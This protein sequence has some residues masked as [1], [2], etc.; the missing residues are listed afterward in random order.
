MVR[1]LAIFF[2]RTTAA[3]AAVVVWLV[4]PQFLRANEQTRADQDIVFGTK[5]FVGTKAWVAAKG[6]LTADWMAYKNNSFSI[7]CDPEACT[8]ASV[9]QIGPKQVGS[10]DGPTAYPVK[11]WAE[12]DE[13]VAEDDTLCSRITITLDR[14]TESV[15]WVET[16]RP[17]LTH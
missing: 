6:T 2:A 10:I 17:V 12:D 8:V 5:L 16:P 13:V 14:K 7:L 11:Q 9:N 4:A 15:L 1:A 3:L